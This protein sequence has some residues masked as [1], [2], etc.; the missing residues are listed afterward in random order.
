MPRPPAPATSA[1]FSTARNARWVDEPGRTV[2]P[3][4]TMCLSA[5][6]A[7]R[8]ER[9]ARGVR[10]EEDRFIL[11]HRFTPPLLRLM[12]PA[13]LIQTGALFAFW[14]VTIW[15][16]QIITKLFGAG[17]PAISVSNVST[18]TAMLNLGG[19]VG[20]ASWGVIADAIGR[21][22]AFFTSFAAILVGVGVLYP[23]SHSWTA[24]LRLLP[25]VGFGIF[26][27]LG[28]PNIMFPELFPTGVRAS[29]IA[30]SNSVGRLFPAAG[31]LVGATIAG[32]FFGGN[33]GMA[34]TGISALAVLGVIGVVLIPESRG[35]QLEDVS[36][37][38]GAAYSGATKI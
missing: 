15:T 20:Y 35:V 36:E 23:F 29:A 26:G 25:V 12:L 14:S 8:A 16:P 31:P 17:S 37:S 10:N 33:L 30:I 18:A 3:I 38:G 9:R 19:I 32:Q 5:V 24:Y 6:K 13:I 28:G 34:V 2:P 22:E 4:P 21:R 27:A 7:R 11:R 1:R